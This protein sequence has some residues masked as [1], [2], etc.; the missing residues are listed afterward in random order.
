[1][2][3]A[4]RKAKQAADDDRRAREFARSIEEQAAHDEWVAL[5]YGVTWVPAEWYAPNVRVSR[6]A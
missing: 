1:M 3:T 2:T 6:R 4:Q 5:M